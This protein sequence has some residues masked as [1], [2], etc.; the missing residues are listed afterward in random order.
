MEKIE[1]TAG[2]SRASLKGR[3]YLAFSLSSEVYGIDILKVKEII[4][5]PEITHVPRL[6]AFIRGVVNLR[7]KII[8]VLDLRLKLDFEP[9]EYDERT[10]I[11]ILEVDTAEGLIQL[12]VIIDRVLDV[13]NLTQEQIEP[14]PSFGVKI[15]TAFILGM[16]KVNNKVISIL[17][18]QQLLTTE[19]MSQLQ[20]V[21]QEQ[22][23]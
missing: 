20:S 19:D 10:C 11:I 2:R 13:M 1:K 9:R 23:Q 6:P 8:P 22:P 7:G 5:V 12:G 14:S 15:N 3:K 21:A 16:A 18:I 17:D 4:G